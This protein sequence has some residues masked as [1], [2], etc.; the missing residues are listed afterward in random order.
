[1]STATTNHADEDPAP[2]SAIYTIDG[3][4][5]R[6]K[7]LEIVDKIDDNVKATV[8][9][10]F[11]PTTAVERAQ[12]ADELNENVEK[13]IGDMKRLN[14]M[15]DFVKPHQERE[16]YAQQLQELVNDRDQVIRKLA[17]ELKTVE[18]SLT[19]A[20][21][22]AQRKMKAINTAQANKVNSEQVVRYANLISRSYSV[23]AP[24]TWVQGD[25]SRPF[26]TEM[27]FASGIVPSAMDMIRNVNSAPTP[28]GPQSSATTPNVMP[29]QVR[30]SPL[31]QLQQQRNWTPAPRSNV[32]GSPQQQSPNQGRTGRG[33]PRGSSNSSPR[34]AAPSILQRR[35]S[36]NTTAASPQLTSPMARPQ[37]QQ[38]GM[39]SNYPPANLPPL[40]IRPPMGRVSGQL[41]VEKPSDNPLMSS[42]SSSDSDD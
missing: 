30:A 15:L 33:R 3:R 36:G 39:K 14:Q 37:N 23:A 32:Y 31:A 40:Q 21:F 22:Q 2:E 5:L 41:S 18:L 35:T 28:K 13:I 20:T 4:S 42:S 12:R 10:L 8:D 24:F 19:E 26:P 7:L 25:P 17:R 27:D 11:L 1:M 9:C 29:G 38:T 16:E 6:E 34:T